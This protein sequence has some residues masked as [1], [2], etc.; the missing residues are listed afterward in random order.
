[1]GANVIDFAEGGD[2]G[3]EKWSKIYSEKSHFEDLLGYSYLELPF[4]GLLS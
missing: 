2:G 4:L 1:M 3:G